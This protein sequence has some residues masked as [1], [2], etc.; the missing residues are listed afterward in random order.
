MSLSGIGSNGT[1]HNKLDDFIPRL[2]EHPIHTA[3]KRTT[4]VL[5]QI[6]RHSMKK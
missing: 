5:P 3:A 2:R 1:L 6:K 4:E